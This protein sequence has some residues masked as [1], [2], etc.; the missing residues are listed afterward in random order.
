[1]TYW[2][3]PRITISRLITLLD[4]FIAFIIRHGNNKMSFSSYK[5]SIFTFYILINYKIAM[6]FKL[7]YFPNM[8]DFVIIH[9]YSCG[10]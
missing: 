8:V 5:F 1:M 2:K 6:I 4:S 7:I 9:N 10:M 3:T